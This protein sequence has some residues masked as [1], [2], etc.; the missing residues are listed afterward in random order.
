MDINYNILKEFKSVTDA[1]KEINSNTTRITHAFHQNRILKKFRWKF[2]NQED[3]KDEIWGK[4]EIN[5]YKINVSSKGRVENKLNGKFLEVKLK[6]I[7][8]SEKVVEIKKNLVFKFI[9]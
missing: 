4:I 6:V 1:S 7:C 2:K 8:V 3:L 5:G 9:D